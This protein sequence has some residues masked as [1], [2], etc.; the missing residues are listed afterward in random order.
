MMTPRIIAMM[1]HCVSEIRLSC[2][3]I[4]IYAGGVIGTGG[5]PRRSVEFLNPYVK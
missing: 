1:I 3:Q 4:P 2:V 5:V